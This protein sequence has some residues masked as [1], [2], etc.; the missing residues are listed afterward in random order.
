MHRRVVIW[1]AVAIVGVVAAALL[2]SMRSALRTGPDAA[3]SVDAQRGIL[4]RDSAGV[5]ISELNWLP[6]DIEVLDTAGA[7][8]LIAH[9]EHPWTMVNGAAWL[10]D[11]TLVVGHAGEYRLSI[12]ARPGRIPSLAGR[13]G[14]GPGELEILGWLGTGPDTTLYTYDIR[15]RRVTRFNRIGAPLADSTLIMPGDLPGAGVAGVFRSGR[16]VLHQVLTPLGAQ[17]PVR[18]EFDTALV[19]IGSAGRE[20]WQRIGPLLL[21]DWSVVPSSGRLR[22][23]ERAYGRVPR[24]FGRRAMVS[25]GT[26]LLFLGQ[27]DSLHIAALDDQ[28]RT[29]AL[30]RGRLPR[31]RLTDA[32]VARARVAAMA[33]M[34]SSRAREAAAERY[35][36]FPDV[37]DRTPALD[38]A[39]LVDNRDRLWLRLFRRPD[40][41]REDWIRWD[42]VSGNVVRYSLP[43]GSDLL[44]AR[45]GSVLGR[46][47]RSDGS[48]I[49][50]VLA[51]PGNVD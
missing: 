39:S 43:P 3:T 21:D 35:R 15:A 40:D 20:E 9:P 5:L 50:R 24:E 19:Y 33:A 28:G 41:P 51:L 7:A 1:L 8:E 44:A 42:P 17:G 29:R 23:G 12:Y 45:D 38:G 2:W 30:L 10:E 27:S 11:G 48:E 37:P 13:R 46:W 34:S 32:I 6:A 36:A 4:I 14:S 25:V 26:R 22:N 47:E 18:V 31:H 49:L 16:V